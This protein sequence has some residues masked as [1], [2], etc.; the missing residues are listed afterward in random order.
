MRTRDLRVALAIGLIA[1]APAALGQK[2]F[3][4]PDGK[5]GTIFQQT[6]CEDTPQE[7]EAHKKAEEARKAEAQRKADEEARKNQEAAQ[8]AK[9]RDQAYQEQLKQRE[10]VEKKNKA[11][12]QTMLGGTTKE[13]GFDDGTLPPGFEKSHP[14]AWKEVPSEDITTTL[15]KNKTPACPQYRYRQRGGGLPEFVVQCTVDKVNWVTY[16]VWPKA[17]TV[18]GPAKF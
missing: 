11:V 8:K 2:M 13:K 18:K 15:A 10:E 9:E 14:G 17:D 1:S 16:F 12:E 3:K 6:K 7:I 4:C 5:G